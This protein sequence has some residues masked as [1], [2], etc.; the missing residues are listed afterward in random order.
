MLAWEWINAARL[1]IRFRDNHLRRQNANMDDIRGVFLQLKKD[2][3]YRLGKTDKMQTDGGGG[4]IETPGLSPRP[5]ADVVTGI[6][7]ERELDG[8]N[9]D[10]E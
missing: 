5:E 3:K 4:R 6:D 9:A 1:A 10:D 2:I 8:S 7:R